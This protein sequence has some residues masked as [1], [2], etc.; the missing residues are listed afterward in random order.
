MFILTDD[1]KKLLFSIE[2]PTIKATIKSDEIKEFTGRNFIDI[3]APYNMRSTLVAIN[4]K[5]AEMPYM[6]FQ[7]G[8]DLKAIKV[9][10]NFSIIR[11]NRVAKKLENLNQNPTL[12]RFENLA[13]EANFIESCWRKP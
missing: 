6:F 1:E 9:Q 12:N 4:A 3:K 11:A 7:G 5:D 10:D 2:K 13:K 8:D